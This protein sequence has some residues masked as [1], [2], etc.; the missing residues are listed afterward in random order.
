MA[1]NSTI[2]QVYQQNTSYNTVS[3]PVLTSSVLGRILISI[4]PII[5]LFY[6]ASETHVGIKAVQTLA[7]NH[8][9]SIDPSQSQ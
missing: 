5:C 6:T 9:T 3:T 4:L 7:I 8:L 1:K 2:L